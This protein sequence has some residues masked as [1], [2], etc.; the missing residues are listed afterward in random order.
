MDEYQRMIT[1]PKYL[2][3]TQP[4]CGDPIEGT[5]NF[6]HNVQHLDVDPR[7]LEWSYDEEAEEFRAWLALRTIEEWDAIE[8]EAVLAGRDIQFRALA[9]ELFG[10]GVEVAVITEDGGHSIVTGDPDQK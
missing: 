4:E 6:I 2:Q 8:Q 3:E 10:D 5:Q 7:V 1:F 9:R